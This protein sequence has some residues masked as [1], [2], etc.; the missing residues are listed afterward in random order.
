MKVLLEAGVRAVQST[1]L[2]T[3]SGKFLGVITTYYQTP[4]KPDEF[5]LRL[6]D[7]LVRQAADFVERVENEQKIDEYAKNLEMN[8]TA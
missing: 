6:L 2:F 5:D 7:L 3:R 1:P 4:H 8:W